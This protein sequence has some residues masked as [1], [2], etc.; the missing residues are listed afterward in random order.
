VTKKV[1]ESFVAGSRKSDGGG[2]YGKSKSVRL[3]WTLWTTCV[4]FGSRDR[5]IVAQYLFPKIAITFSIMVE[6]TVENY[7][8][9]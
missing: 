6:I 4:A 5:L 8:A 9:E 7:I 3:D 1:K 2:G